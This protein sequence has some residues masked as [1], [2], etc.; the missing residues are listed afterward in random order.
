VQDI[1]FWGLGWGSGFDLIK[2][3]ALFNFRSSARA[4]PA[5]IGKVGVLGECCSE[6]LGIVAIPRFHESVD[7]RRDCLPV[8]FAVRLAPQ[9]QK[10]SEDNRQ[11]SQKRFPSESRSPLGVFLSASNTVSFGPRFRFCLWRSLVTSLESVD[12]VKHSANQPLSPRLNCPCRLR[13]VFARA[14]ATFG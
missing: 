1:R 9:G 2:S 8:G 7:P 6:S 4:F 11:T 5:P 14:A 13:F 12:S 10:H 3:L